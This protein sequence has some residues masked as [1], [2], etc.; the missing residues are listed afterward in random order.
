MLNLNSWNNP[1]LYMK[2]IIHNWKGC[3]NIYFLPD[4]YQGDFPVVYLLYFPNHILGSWLPSSIGESLKWS[5]LE[6]LVKFV[7]E[8]ICSESGNLFIR[9]PFVFVRIYLSIGYFH[10]SPTQCKILRHFISADNSISNSIYS[11]WLTCYHIFYFFF[12]VM[13]FNFMSFLMLY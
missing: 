6:Y 5:I 4:R 7:H 13:F 3:A 1:D 12:S 2:L 11:L 10:F 9:N 8:P